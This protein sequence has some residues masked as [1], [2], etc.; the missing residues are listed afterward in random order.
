MCGVIEKGHKRKKTQSMREFDT[1]GEFLV[2]QARV[3]S[4]GENWRLWKAKSGMPVKQLPR[5]LEVFLRLLIFL[6][7]INSETFV[8][9]RSK[10]SDSLSSS[11]IFE[12]NF[13]SDGKN[14]NWIFMEVKM[15][16]DKNLNHGSRQDDQK[17][18]LIWHNQYSENF[19][20][21]WNELVK[22]RGKKNEKFIF[23]HFS[24]IPSYTTYG[25]VDFPTGLYAEIA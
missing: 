3:D 1:Q 7:V 25:R 17:H 5:N 11:Y 23:N 13:L 18:G 6:Y 2:E 21:C 4:Q 19:S 24:T 8:C 12:K 15:I 20:V 10:Y 22:E 16:N 14:W 9:M